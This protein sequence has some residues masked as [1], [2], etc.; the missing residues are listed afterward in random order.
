MRRQEVNGG[1]TRARGTMQEALGILSGDRNLER[2]DPGPRA[3]GAYQEEFGIEHRYGDE[4]VT[5]LGNAI[6]KK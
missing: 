3:E 6:N 1:S 4:V 2:E 5:D